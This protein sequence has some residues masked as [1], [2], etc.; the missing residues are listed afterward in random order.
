M[1]VYQH[2]KEIDDKKLQGLLKENMMIDKE[3][4]DVSHNQGNYNL[5]HFTNSTQTT[6]GRFIFYLSG[7][8]YE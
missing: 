5:K 1:T 2:Q 4:K 6:T 8:R 3:L 7:L